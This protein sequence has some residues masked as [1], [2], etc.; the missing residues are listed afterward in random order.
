MSGTRQKVLMA[1]MAA[2]FV[3][4]NL[5]PAAA[6]TTETKLIVVNETGTGITELIISPSSKH[7]PKNKSCIVFEDLRKS[8]GAVFGVMLPGYVTT[9]ADIFDIAIAAGGKRFS[10]KKGV[11]IDFS[12]GKTPTLHLSTTNKDIVQGVKDAAPNLAAAA[13]FA[14]TKK[15]A[16]KA[17]AAALVSAVSKIGITGAIP[18]LG[19]ILAGGIVLVEGAFFLHDYVFATGDLWVQ[20]DYN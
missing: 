9:E 3:L 19:W 8:A 7:Y 14:T 10:T 20:V 4:G 2:A 12:N 6:K 1:V 16:P 18:Y 17:G 15:I 5:V 13:F 11:K